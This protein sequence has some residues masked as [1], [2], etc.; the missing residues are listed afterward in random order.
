MADLSIKRGD[1]Y[2]PLR[3]Q[4][5]ERDPT[6]VDPRARRAISLSG[7]TSVAFRAKSRDERRS[8]GGPCV[9]TDA[10]NGWVEWTLDPAFT[11]IYD[12]FYGEFEIVWTSGGSQTVPNDGYFEIEIVKDLG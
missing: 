12:F 4:L 11:Q 6:S 8:F 9:V 1:T 3:A 2:P 10:P 5:T 7:A